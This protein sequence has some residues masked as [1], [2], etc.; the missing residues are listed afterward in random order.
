[1][2]CQ[3]FFKMLR[4]ILIPLDGSPL[5]R[6]ALHYAPAMLTPGGQVTLL[7]VLSN[8]DDDALMADARAYLGREAGQ[9]RQRGLRPTC[10][11]RFGQVAE[12]IVATARESQVDAV[13]MATHG[14]TGFDRWL[15][16]SVTMQVLDELVCPLMVIPGKEVVEAK[17]PHVP[18]LMRLSAFA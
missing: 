11:V 5:A 18:A 15:Y 4:H 12:C 7:G 9:L 6:Q 16:G 14:R 13:L 17:Q 2:E 1:M 3:D 8:P 10:R